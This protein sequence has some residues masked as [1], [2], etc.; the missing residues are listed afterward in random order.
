M[1]K[2]RFTQHT[3]HWFIRLTRSKSLAIAC[4]MKQ[5]DL[6]SKHEKTFFQLRKGVKR[7]PFLFNAMRTRKLEPRP[8]GLG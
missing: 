7:V 3:A 6:N 4:N 5:G 1:K 8:G 2:S